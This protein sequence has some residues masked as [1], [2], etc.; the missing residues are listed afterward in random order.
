MAQLDAEH[1]GLD[2]IHATI[3]ADHGVMIFADLSVVA[4]DADRFVE[5]GVV[6]DDSAGFPESAEIFPGIKAEAPCVA[7]RSRLAAFVFCS[8]R[9][10]GI[11]DDKEPV[12][13]TEPFKGR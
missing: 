12:S 1:G 4:Q 7:Y 5:G 8:M 13:I 2:S 3:P 9:L 11:F 10:A 6:G